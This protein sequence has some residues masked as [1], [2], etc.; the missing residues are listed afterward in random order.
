MSDDELWTLIGR[1]LD[2]GLIPSASSALRSYP[3]HGECGT[4]AFCELPVAQ[5]DTQ[6]AI[7]L[8]SRNRR[9]GDAQEGLGRTL[10]AHAKCL[11]IWVRIKA[12]D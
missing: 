5:T 8:A 1:R 7:D 12:A 2:A 4:C 9:R 10:L 11:Q 6:Y 3:A